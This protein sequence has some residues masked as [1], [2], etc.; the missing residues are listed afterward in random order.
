[1]RDSLRACVVL[2]S[3]VLVLAGAAVSADEIAVEGHGGAFVLNASN[4]A[5]ALFDSDSGPSF[6]GAVRWT[7]WRGAFAAGGA[8]TFSKE[9]ERVFVAA[10]N[11]PV[12]KLGFPLSIR[13]TPVFAVV[14]YRFRNGALVVPYVQAGGTLTLYSE[15]SSVAGE[16]F[17][18]SF[19][20]AGFIGGGGVEVGRG[21][22]RF[23]AEAGWSTVPNA[24]GQGSTSGD[25]GGVAKLYGD[26]D[27]G[28]R[29][30]IAK[31]VVVL[32]R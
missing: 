3:A 2:A 31:L 18:D 23:A 13:T 27:I 8:R 5:S 12:Q 24:I 14:G 20:K 9:G 29:Y 16:D 15:T 7:F 22:F 21:R 32:F 25:L 19:S 1:M 6:G 4:T 30:A 26:D 28:G 10:P 11:A 17:D